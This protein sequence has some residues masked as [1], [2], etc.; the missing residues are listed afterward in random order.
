MTFD[1][2]PTG[3]SWLNQV[4]IW[5]NILTRQALDGASLASLDELVQALHDYTAKYNEA[6]RPFKSVQVAQTRSPRHTAPQYG[7]ELAD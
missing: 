3:A 5:L 1:F 2:T 7:Q 6:A 4:E